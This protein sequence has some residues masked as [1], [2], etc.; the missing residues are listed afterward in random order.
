MPKVITKVCPTL[1]LPGFF[2]TVKRF[3]PEENKNDRCK[4]FEHGGVTTGS[5]F[6]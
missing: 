5:I 2:Q 4:T 3:S 6:F 1:D